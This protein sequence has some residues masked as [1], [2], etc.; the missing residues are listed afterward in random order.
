MEVT[1]GVV[2]SESWDLVKSVMSGAITV[3]G[4]A[5]LYLFNQIQSLKEKVSENE[6]AIALNDQH[7]TTTDNVLSEIKD[8]LKTIDKKID[9]I[10][11]K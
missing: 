6:K 11:M 4:F 10:L 5:L 9:M 1:T 2:N 7:D 8:N 3:L